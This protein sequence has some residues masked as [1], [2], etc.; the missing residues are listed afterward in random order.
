[1]L[2]IKHCIWG[3]VA[4]AVGVSALFAPSDMG[5][6]I[7]T[8]GINTPVHAK[9]DQ[10]VRCE[11]APSVVQEEA[12]PL[13][14]R[15][16]TTHVGSTD[17]KTQGFRNNP[18]AR[19]SG[20]PP[21]ARRQEQRADVPTRLPAWSTPAVFPSTTAV[22]PKM[23]VAATRALQRELKRHGCYAGEADGDWGPASRYA[24][25]IFTAAVN[26]KLPVDKPNEFLLALSRNHHD[27]VCTQ[28]GSITTAS[29]TPIRRVTVATDT[30][31]NRNVQPPSPSSV[32]QYAPRFTS[33]PRIVR[34]NS[35]N[36]AMAL[37]EMPP[38]GE[39]MALGAEPSAPRSES[40]SVRRNSTSQRR[41]DAARRAAARSR[42]RRARKRAS[43]K[44]W[45]RQV[46]Q[47]IN[48]SGS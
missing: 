16:K 42:Q 27:P 11:P 40:N 38:P 20:P 18:M 46:F 19:A 41:R 30:M 33:P 9:T 34:G 6:D 8:T 7:S 22:A 10:V 31:P 26:A 17:A 39:M 32:S 25:A 29:T 24:A 43:R 37:T 4:G 23:S 45:K 48:M 21:I 12:K 5:A 35:M 36:P 1:M 44:R 15:L 2:T 28:A 14:A 47:S 3:I 13:A